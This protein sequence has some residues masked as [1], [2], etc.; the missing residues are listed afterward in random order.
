M[1]NTPQDILRYLQHQIPTYPFDHLIDAAFIDELLT[2]FHD[3]DILEEAKAFRWYYDN[4]PAARL[5]NVRLSL[6]RWIA[7]AHA[8]RAAEP[9]Q[10]APH[11][12]PTAAEN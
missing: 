9:A 11:R 3:V 8:Q 6:R 7:K 10:N 1:S 5:K 4:R 12:Q 2:D